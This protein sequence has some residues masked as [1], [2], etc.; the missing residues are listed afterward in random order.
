MTKYLLAYHGGTMAESETEQAA[1]MAAWGEWFASLGSAVVDGGNPVGAT[2]TI[3]SD[4]RTAPA[5]DRTP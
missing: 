5:A 1:A 3:A 2:T 4:G